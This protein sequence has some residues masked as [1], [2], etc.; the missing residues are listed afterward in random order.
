MNSTSTPITT[1]ALFHGFR[2]VDADDVIAAKRNLPDKPCALHSLPTPFLKAIVEIVP[3]HLTE[4][5]HRSLSTRYVPETFK[6]AYIEP[7]LKKLDMGPAT[8]S[9]EVT[10]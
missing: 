4:L 7:L 2:E 8:C 3:P 6:T 5:G 10:Y 1:D 9:D